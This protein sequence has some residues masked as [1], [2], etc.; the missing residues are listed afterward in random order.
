MS[1]LIGVTATIT[2]LE[3][4]NSFSSVFPFVA[5]AI[6][7]AI[8]APTA[9]TFPSSSTDTIC[10]LLLVHFTSGDAVSGFTVAFN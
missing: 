2:D 7:C 10:S 3:I 1:L 9:T 4:P 8:P 6:I 5:V